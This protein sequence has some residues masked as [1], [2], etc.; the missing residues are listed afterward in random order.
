MENTTFEKTYGTHSE[1]LNP[2][3]LVRVTEIISMIVKRRFKFVHVYG[4]G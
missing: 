2:A 3:S 1:N 4:T